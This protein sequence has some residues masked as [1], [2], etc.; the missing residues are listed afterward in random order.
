MQNRKERGDACT[1]R[2]LCIPKAMHI[3]LSLIIYNSSSRPGSPLHVSLFPGSATGLVARR[4]R[5]IH[6]LVRGLLTVHPFGYICRCTRG[7][8]CSVSCLDRVWLLYVTFVWCAVWALRS[9]F[10]A[11]LARVPA[12]LSISPV[13]DEAEIGVHGLERC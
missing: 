9:L 7:T 3:N 11:L 1:T 2:V 13:D 5:G 8:V 4:E 12:L 6:F 10:C